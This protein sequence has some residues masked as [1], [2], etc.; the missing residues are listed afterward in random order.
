MELNRV[1]I[2]NFKSIKELKFELSENYHVLAGKNESGK[3]NILEAISY[4]DPKK[5]PEIS[6]IREPLPEEKSVENSKIFFVFTPEIEEELSVLETYKTHFLD[7]DLVEEMPL[8]KYYGLEYS[9]EGY[10]NTRLE[11]LIFINF[12]KPSRTF[13][14]WGTSSTVKTIGGWKKVTDSCPADAKVIDKNGDE[15]K[16]KKGLILNTKLYESIPKEYLEDLTPEF[17]STIIGDSLVTILK[18]LSFDC[19]HWFYDSKNL[20][21][22][23]VVLAGFKEN[24]DSCLPLKYLFNLAGIDDI[25]ADLDIASSKSTKAIRNLLKRVS[26]QA[27]SFFNEKWKEYDNIE[28]NL[29]VNGD[30]IEI[31]ILEQNYFDFAQRSDGFKRFITFLIMISVKVQTNQLYNS[32]ILIDE[33]EISLHPSG[34]RYLRD[35]LRNISIT[36]TVVF[37]THSIF[38]VDP[39]DLKNHFVVKKELEET[40]VTLVESSDIYDEEVVY[41]ALGHSMFESLKKKNILFEGWR[42]KHLFKVA[43]SRIPATYKKLKVLKEYGL[44]HS[45]GVKGIRH[46]TPILELA[47]RECIITSDSDEPA[48]EQQKDFNKDPQPY[49]WYCFDDLLKEEVA[50]TAEDFIKPA[51]IINALENYSEKYEIPK[52]TAEKLEHPKGKIFAIKEWLKTS[53]KEDKKPDLNGFKTNLFENLKYTQ[54][55]TKYY[56][57]LEQILQVSEKT[58]P[59]Y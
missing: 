47:N 42:D 40:K 24:P 15:R 49:K 11:C 16:I 58:T 3:T 53:P 25:K 37:S 46:I 10:F 57:F 54:I 18:K 48:K 14:Y 27:T 33:P 32:I 7:Y 34:Q 6:H 17:I 29:T 5:K 13:T 28:F 41:N 38:M 8:F 22:S 30:N 59:P 51:P 4:L 39:E 56:S 26:T 2:R 50:V 43:I 36:N 35:E 9:A 44:A 31:S 21:P 45:K 1:D 55:E 20:L 52:I 23:K 12:T 19:I